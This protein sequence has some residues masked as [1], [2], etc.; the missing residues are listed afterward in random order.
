MIKHSKQNKLNIFIW[1]KMFHTIKLF[2]WNIGYIL[3]ENKA[4]KINY[5]H[6]EKYSQIFKICQI[7][8]NS[9]QSGN[10]E[11]KKAIVQ[12][13]FPVSQPVFTYPKSI[14]KTL[15]GVKHIWYYKDQTI[16]FVPTKV[17]FYMK[18]GFG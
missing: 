2:S 18:L 10:P 1:N 7:P 16:L 9:W 17:T 11:F 5:I 8:D 13:T 14:A 12:N 15:E 3:K 4:S 6:I